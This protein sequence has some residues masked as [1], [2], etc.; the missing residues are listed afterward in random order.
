VIEQSRRQI[1]SQAYLERNVTAPRP[2]ADEV[3]SFYAEQPGLFQKRR[4]YSFRD[5]VIERPKYSD[6]LRGKLESAKTRADVAA[7]LKAANVDFREAASV[8]G[9]E[10]LP[11]DMLPR[12]MAMAKG[13][14]S[15]LVNDKTVILMQLTDFTEQPVALQQAT[16]YIEQYLMNAKRKQLSESKLKELRAAAKIAYLAPAANSQ[17]ERKTELTPQPAAAAADAPRS[18]EASIKKGL[19]G[20]TG[21]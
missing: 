4:I 8:R 17:D 14:I 13:D 16:P 15:A 3:K 2:G 21:K 5:Y 12:V 18:G 1:L 9:A 10:Q 19:Q 7:A 6:A 20:L 11:I